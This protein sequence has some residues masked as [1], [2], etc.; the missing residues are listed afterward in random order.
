[1]SSHSVILIKT[2]FSKADLQELIEKEGNPKTTLHKLKNF[3]NGCLGGARSAIIDMGAVAN[4]SDPV[5]AS[6]AAVF[7]GIP[8]DAETLSINGV[9]IT[10]VDGAPDNNEVQRDDTPTVAQ[11]ANRLADAINNSTSDALAGVVKATS[12]GVDT[13]SVECLMPG[14][15]GNSIALADSAA[16][17]AWAGAATALSGGTGRLPSLSQFKFAR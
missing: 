7:T 16:N 11:L 4:S 10:F 6:K 17:V 5:A 2:D 12:N 15:I 9:N 3:L 1:M 13:V 8:A 14:V